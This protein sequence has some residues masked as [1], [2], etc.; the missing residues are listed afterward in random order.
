V[1]VDYVD[2]Q[3]YYTAESVK[4]LDEWD[5]FMVQPLD[6]G[7]YALHCTRRLLSSEIM[8]QI[9]FCTREIVDSYYL[10]PVTL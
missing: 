10:Q 3:V 7:N 5:I 8:F 6:N 1:K 9:I 2:D 4:D